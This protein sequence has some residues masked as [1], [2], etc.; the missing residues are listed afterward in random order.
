M[1]FDLYWRKL[2]GRDFGRSSS[3]T[4]IRLPPVPPSPGLDFAKTAARVVDPLPGV[5]VRKQG[6]GAVVSKKWRW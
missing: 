1:A 3:L 2:T 4:S 6:K 5:S